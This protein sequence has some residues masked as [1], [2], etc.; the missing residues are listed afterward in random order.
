MKKG[1]VFYISFFHESFTSRTPNTFDTR[2][3]WRHI[4]LHMNEDRYMLGRPTCVTFHFCPKNP[5]FRL[6]LTLRQIWRVMG[7]TL[8]RNGRQQLPF[9][10]THTL[11]STFFIVWKKMRR[12][13]S[14]IS[15]C[16]RHTKRCVYDGVLIKRAGEREVVIKGRKVSFWALIKAS[17]RTEVGVGVRRRQRQQPRL[18]RQQQQQ[19]QPEKVGKQ[20]T[21]TTI[22]GLMEK[23]NS[24][25]SFF[26]SPQKR[27]KF[28]AYFRLLR[29]PWIFPPVDYSTLPHNI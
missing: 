14:P 23:R 19:Q 9:F 10:S 21:R 17:K 27:K 7:E 15:S 28:R 4:I 20:R 24:F 3:G 5:I 2:I 8:Q 29:S 16:T 22:V 18:K 6:W 26:L 1:E 12:K 11:L 25:F 13:S